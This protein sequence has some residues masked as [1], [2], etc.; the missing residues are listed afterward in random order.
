MEV[1]GETNT[2][3]YV[4]DTLTAAWN[5]SLSLSLVCI[6]PEAK[7]DAEIGVVAGCRCQ[8]TEAGAVNGRKIV[9]EPVIS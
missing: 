5:P 9:S 8:H 2:G 4:S 3:S 7:T 1:S 6:P